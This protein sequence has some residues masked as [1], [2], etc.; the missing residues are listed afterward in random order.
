MPPDLQHCHLRRYI[1]VTKAIDKMFIGSI[2]FQCYFATT[3]LTTRHQSLRSSSRLQRLAECTKLIMV[4]DINREAF[5]SNDAK[6][7][8]PRNDRRHFTLNIQV[9]R[10]SLPLYSVSL[11]RRIYRP[12][13]AAILRDKIGC[14]GFLARMLGKRSISRCTE[15]LYSHSQCLIG[16]S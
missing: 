1:D 4:P 11:H 14:F 8:R 13:P 6:I 15:T 5:T 10:H 3:R 2:H 7:K 12:V 9:R 16:R